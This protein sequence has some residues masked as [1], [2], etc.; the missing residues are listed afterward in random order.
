MF[1]GV[2]IDVVQETPST[3]LFKVALKGGVFDFIPGQFA[4]LSLDDLV[5]EKGHIIKRS[6]SIASSPLNK[7][8]LEFCITIAPDGRFTPH[9]DKLRSGD[10]INVS[11]PYGKFNLHE[12]QEYFMKRLFIATGAGIAPLMSM[13][14]TLFTQYGDLEMQLLYGFR[15]P[16]V[17]CYM[18]ELS[19]YAMRFGNFELCPTISAK[20]IPPYWRG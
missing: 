20:D 17:F 10:K 19:E 11:E 3:K 12:P 1:N 13:M 4:I 2:I 18:Q 6:Y 16:E 15:N 9:L 8:Y 7:D 5:N 14:R